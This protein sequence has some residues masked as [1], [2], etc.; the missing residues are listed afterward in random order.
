MGLRFVHVEPGPRSEDWLELRL[1]ENHRP[2]VYL[3][4]VRLHRDRRAAPDTE[5][6]RDVAPQVLARLSCASVADYVE[7]GLVL[8]RARATLVDRV[9]DTDF[10]AGGLVFTRSTE[11]VTT[12]LAP[13]ER[14]VFRVAWR[15]EHALTYWFEGRVVELCWASSA[16]S[17][18]A[19]VRPRAV[20]HGFTYV[21]WALEELEPVRGKLLES[22]R[23]FDLGLPL[24]VTE[25][26]RD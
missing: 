11:L 13:R 19:R 12:T 26:F 20:E 14:S 25:P 6:V 8:A 2:P 9:K 5:H 3:A 15:G 22:P 17:A 7:K 4:T 10:E 24:E 18:G 21:P 1:D 16:F 23:A